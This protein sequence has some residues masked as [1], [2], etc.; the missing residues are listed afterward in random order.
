[1]LTSVK[2]MNSYGTISPFFTTKN[3]RYISNCLNIGTFKIVH[4]ILCFRAPG[5][6][7]CGS[8]FQFLDIKKYFLIKDS[9]NLST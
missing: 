1:M 7:K 8:F 4:D 5:F 2:L 9:E 6:Q 3:S